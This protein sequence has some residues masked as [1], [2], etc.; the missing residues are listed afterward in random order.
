LFFNFKRPGLAAGV[1]SGKAK[2]HR[3]LVGKTT[4]LLSASIVVWFL[5]K[6]PN[7]NPCKEE[8]LFFEL[9]GEQAQRRG[10]QCLN[11]Y[12]SLTFLFDQNSHG[13]G[14]SVWQINFNHLGRYWG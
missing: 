13:F 2:T 4:K 12:F 3:F 10:K 9:V 5:T 7:L 6:S 11:A 1:P 8:S 14:A